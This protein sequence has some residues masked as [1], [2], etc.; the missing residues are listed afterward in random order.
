MQASNREEISTSPEESSSNKLNE[1]QGRALKEYLLFMFKKDNLSEIDPYEEFIPIYR[2]SDTMTTSY[3]QSLPET[4]TT[5]SQLHNQKEQS[6]IF[7]TDK[8]ERI[9]PKQPLNPAVKTVP[10]DLNHV[11]P[12]QVKLT[13]PWNGY[14][15]QLGVKSVQDLVRVKTK[16]TEMVELSQEA[17]YGTVAG[18]AARIRK[19]S[20]QKQSRSALF[21]GDLLNSMKAGFHTEEF[22]RQFGCI[23]KNILLNG[24]RRIDPKDCAKIGFIT[25][26]IDPNCMVDHWVL[27]PH[28]HLLHWPLDSPPDLLQQWGLGAFQFRCKD[29]SSG[30]ARILFWVTTDRILDALCSWVTDGIIGRIHFIDEKKLQLETYPLNGRGNWCENQA[31]LT[32]KQANEPGQVTLNW[33]MKYVVFPKRFEKQ[34]NLVPI[35]KDDRYPKMASYL[36]ADPRQ[37][38]PSDIQML[39]SQGLK[40]ANN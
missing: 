32:E 17:N 24:I 37:D 18:T 31:D 34:K 8:A 29:P 40:E 3:S 39:Y 27:I 21:Y 2:V 20:V 26:H 10:Y 9:G 14:D 38:Q 4:P 12:I 35:W 30:E 33:S 28:R 36:N 13:E 7:G 6:L 15:I 11:C 25:K 19:K 16:Q 5:L 23:S 22:Q 1:N